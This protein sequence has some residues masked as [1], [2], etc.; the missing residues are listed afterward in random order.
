[1]SLDAIFVDLLNSDMET[2]F[3]EIIE[4]YRDIVPESKK[5]DFTLEKL[6]DTFKITDIKRVGQP[7]FVNKTRKKVE[8]CNRCMAR[9]W[10]STP[11][12]AYYCEI[13]KKYIYGQRCTK[14]KNGDGDYCKLHSKNLPHGKFGE[15]PPHEHFEKYL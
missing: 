11:P 7:E 13:K 12:V 3:K 10:G 15:L 9:I 2:M 14:P 8:N 5:A 4:E 1:M 6:I